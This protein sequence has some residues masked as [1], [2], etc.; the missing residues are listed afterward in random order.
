MAEVPINQGDL[1]KA[2]R[3]YEQAALALA[4]QTGDKR[5]TTANSGTSDVIYIQQ[6][7][8]ITGRQDV[9]EALDVYRQILTTSTE[10]R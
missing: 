1:D 8:L 2:R 3:L 10:W 7:D 4:R 9:R 5:A 6:G